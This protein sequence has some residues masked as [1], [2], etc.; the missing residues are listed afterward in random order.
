VGTTEAGQ[1]GGVTCWSM[2]VWSLTKYIT[3]IASVR[4]LIGSLFISVS[5]SVRS[6][7]V[8]EANVLL[9]KCVA[10]VPVQ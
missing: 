3:T 4:R 2:V 1:A 8:L 10:H 7:A 6:K 9:S 5:G